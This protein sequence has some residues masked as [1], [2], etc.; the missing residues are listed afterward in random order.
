MKEGTNE[1][2]GNV[3][4]YCSV[5]FDSFDDLKAHVIAE[6]KTE[7]LPKPAGVIDFSVNGQIYEFK[8]E[9]EWTLYQVIHDCFVIGAPAVHARLS[10]TVALFFHV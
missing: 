7:P 4:P 3:C 6:H 1:M 2:S 5:I 9:P 8:V 10:W